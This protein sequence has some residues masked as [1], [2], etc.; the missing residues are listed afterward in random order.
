[1]KYYEA[2]LASVSHKEA[3]GEILKHGDCSL[4]QEFYSEVGKKNE[5]SGQ[6]VLDFLGY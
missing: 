2:C 3:V 4:V 6:E 1:M 5:Y